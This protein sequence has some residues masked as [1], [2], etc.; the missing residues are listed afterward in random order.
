[1]KTTP[2]RASS[3]IKIHRLFVFLILLL[4]CAV[5]S[6]TLIKVSTAQSG[7]GIK[8][9]RAAYP[10]PTLPT[11]PAHGGKFNDPT[12]GTEIMRV[13]DSSDCA[14]PGC[15]T[16]YSHWPTFNSNNTKLLIRNGINGQAILKDFDP[17]NFTAGSGHVALPDAVDVNNNCP[18]CTAGS[19]FGPTWESAIWSNTDPNIIYTFPSYYDGGLK[20]LTFNVQTN[21]FTMLKDL[22][23]ASGGNV[24]HFRQMYMSADNDIFCWIQD[25]QGNARQPWGFTVYKRSTDT[26]LYN[27]ADTYDYAPGGDGGIDEVHVDKSGKWMH[28]VIPYAQPDGTGTRFLNLATGQYQALTRAVDHSPGHG[29]MGTETIIG[30]DNY[31]NGIS[32]RHLVDV[33]DFEDIF[34][35]RAA[36]GQSD[37]TKDFH[38]TMLADNEDWITIGTYLFWDTLASGCCPDYGLFTNEI[39]Q[40]SLDG[41]SKIRRLAHT[42]S[43]VAAETSAGQTLSGLTSKPSN[44]PYWSTP[45]PTISKDG[46]FI[47]FTSNWGNSDR[48]DLFILKITPAPVITPSAPTNLTTTAGSN[49]QISLQWTASSGAINHYEVERKQ[50]LSGQYQALSPNPTTTSFIDSTVTANTAYLYRVRAV[51]MSGQN[52]AYS[53]VHLATAITFTDSLVSYAENPSTATPVRY[54]HVTQLRTAVNAVRA[55]ANLS[56]ATWTNTVQAGATINATDV[57]ELRTKLADALT[58]LGLPAPTYTYPT[59]TEHVSIIHKADIKDLRDAVK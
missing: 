26:V 37:W 55:L 22:S 57:R 5:P 3:A 42:R 8:E 18:T 34:L 30:F 46:K 20:L 53:N 10:E 11:L 1:M 54:Y 45:K 44:D 21:Q 29:D 14:A 28:I 4:L 24:A 23:S 2:K 58:A 9:D 51:S 43:V 49:S 56:A 27:V 50:S 59:I 25:R 41:E 32:L 19:Y 52:S 47:A 35:F 39:V 40:I 38:G 48:Y 31:D 33:H 7:P 15:G 16:Q 17:V 36:G 13:T 12:F 6:T